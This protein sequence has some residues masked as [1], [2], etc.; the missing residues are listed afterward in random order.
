M[1]AFDFDIITL[2]IFAGAV[3]HGY[4][5]AL[6]WYSVD[7]FAAILHASVWKDLLCS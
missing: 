7:N 5:V 1:K 3:L 6:L 4:A 2:Y